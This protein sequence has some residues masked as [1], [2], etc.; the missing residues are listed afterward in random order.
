MISFLDLNAAYCELRSDIDIAVA[1]SLA[2]G[3]YIGGPEVE[4][5][6]H[7][8][9]ITLRFSALHGLILKAFKV[10]RLEYFCR[11]GRIGVVMLNAEIFERGSF[12]P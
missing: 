9:R 4:S 11:A 12:N 10:A 2:L 7:V 6:E 1:R 8:G 5:F 3:C